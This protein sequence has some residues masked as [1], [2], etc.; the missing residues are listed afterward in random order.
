MNQIMTSEDGSTTILS[1]RFGVTYHS[2]H[3]AIQET[4]TVFLEAGYSYALEHFNEIR[5][6]E[7][8]FGTGLNAL[9][10]YDLSFHHPKIKHFY[11]TI[12]AYPIDMGTVD[13]LN[14][15]DLLGYADHIFQTFR[16][17]HEAA[18]QETIVQHNFS[19]TKFITQIQDLA[20]KDEYYNVIYYDAFAPN[21]QEELWDEAMMKKMY[22]CLQ[23]QGCLVTYCAKGSFKRALKAAGFRIEGLPGPKGKRE[24]TRAIK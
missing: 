11:D 24:M 22:N 2:K 16:A 15:I 9:M 6:L 7:M 13:K 3:G 12:E 5:I 21:A 23:D 19:F 17:W 18:S 1:E 8:G 14:Y 10:T 20:L 4:E